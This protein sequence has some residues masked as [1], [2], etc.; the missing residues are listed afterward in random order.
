MT[1]ATR[2]LTVAQKRRADAYDAGLS[3]YQYTGYVSALI[4]CIHHPNRIVNRSGYVHQ[5][6]RQCGSCKTN[7][8]RD[9]SPR[10]AHVRNV[11]KRNYEK[12][13]KLRKYHLA[14]RLYGIRLFERVTGMNLE[15]AGFIGYSERPV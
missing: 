7:K 15:A 9:G 12:S 2:R 13:L 5:R 3:L 8:R 14:G 10:P 4:M 6:K 1:A 11:N